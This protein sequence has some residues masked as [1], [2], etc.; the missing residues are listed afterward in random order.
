MAVLGGIFQGGD[1]NSMVAEAPEEYA[2]AFSEAPYEYPRQ[3]VPMGFMAS[4][5]EFHK[6]VN[7]FHWLDQK[8]L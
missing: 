4:G 3:K 5:G 7:D 1:N 8:H 6:A 2:L